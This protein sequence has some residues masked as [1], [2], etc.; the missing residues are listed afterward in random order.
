MTRCTCLAKEAVD[1]CTELCYTVNLA[2]C[3]EHSHIERNS[4]FV[5]WWTCL[6]MEAGSVENLVPLLTYMGQ[7][8]SH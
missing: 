4:F 2:M 5:T 8:C 1:Q 6:A 7:V 3:V